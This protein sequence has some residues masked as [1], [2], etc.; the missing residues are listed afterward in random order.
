M[1]STAALPFKIVSHSAQ[2]F[3]FLYI[4]A[5]VWCG[6]T[7]KSG[8]SIFVLPS[9][10]VSFGWS[11]RHTNSQWSLSVFFIFHSNGF[12]MEISLCFNLNFLDY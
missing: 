5:N 12:L 6:Q 8:C 9:V 11:L 1:F 10:C 4:V 2:R 7:F 3:Q